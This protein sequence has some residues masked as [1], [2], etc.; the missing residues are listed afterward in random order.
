VT[1]TVV[2]VDDHPLVRDGFRFLAESRPEID[3]VGEAADADGAVATVARLRPDVVVMD[4]E[5]GGGSGIEATARIRD[6]HPECRVLFVTMHGDEATVVAALNAGGSGFVLKGA[7]QEDLVRAIVGAAAGDLVLGPHAGTIL[8]ER[9]RQ[10]P[11]ARPSLPHLTGREH[12]ILEL[13][14]A[15][16]P[17]GAIAAELGVSRKTVANHVANILAKL[18][19]EDRGHAIVLAREAGFG[20]R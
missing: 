17:N 7:P 20:Q 14:A 13:L 9:V 16:R 2:V 18:H 5:L 12:E 8:A 11:V 6:A 4:V 1:V 3:M 15:G 19:A 10:L